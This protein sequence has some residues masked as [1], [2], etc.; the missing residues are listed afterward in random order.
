MSIRRRVEALE[1]VSG[2][3]FRIAWPA[4]LDREGNGFAKNPDD[5]DVAGVRIC[6]GNHCKE[7]WRDQDEPVQEFRKRA[8][9]AAAT[10][11]QPTA[12]LPFGI[13]FV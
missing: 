13:E 9:E 3:G 11:L 6:V 5:A 4:L 1:A 12:I 10:Q 8:C 7:V 2:S